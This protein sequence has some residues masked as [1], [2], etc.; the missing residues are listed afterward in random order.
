MKH[1]FAEEEIQ[2]RAALYALGALGQHE[3]RAFDEHLA[4]GCATC[5]AELKEFATVVEKLAF[6]SPEAAPSPDTRNKLMA[7]IAAGTKEP[8]PTSP[9]A[10]H[11]APQQTVTVRADEGKWFELHAG[12]IVKQLFADPTRKTITTLMRLQPGAQIPTHRHHGMEE[13]YVLE[14][15]VFAND[16]SLKA[17]DYTCAMAGSIHHPISTINGALLLL[18]A[19][20]HYDV[21]EQY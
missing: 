17:G 6:E 2:E 11:D 16:Q 15:D 10:D 4:E 19:P 7:L 12:V 18:V 5:E 3:A 20:D 1:I 21:L 8:P 9:D 14:G 13:C